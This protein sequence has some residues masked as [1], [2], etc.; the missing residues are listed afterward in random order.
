MPAATTVSCSTN[1]R[2]HRNGINS[3]HFCQYSLGSRYRHSCNDAWHG[4]NS[5]WSND[6]LRCSYSRHNYA[7][8]CYYP[9]WGNHT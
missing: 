8:W 6:S 2:D 4:D 5:I 1:N 3:W 7:W 9:E